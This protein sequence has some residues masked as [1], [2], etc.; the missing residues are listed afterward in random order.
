MSDSPPEYHYIDYT[1]IRFPSDQLTLGLIR[2]LHP[3]YFDVEHAP[4]E[5]V[6]AIAPNEDFDSDDD[7]GIGQILYIERKLA[8]NAFEGV[9]RVYTRSNVMGAKDKPAF[10]EDLVKFYSRYG[11]ADGRESAMQLIRDIE[12]QAAN[13]ARG[14]DLGRS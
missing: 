8:L 14:A 11:I 3:D 5:Q 1:L 9:R 13:Q 12:S 4:F 7:P 2:R 6:L 10:V